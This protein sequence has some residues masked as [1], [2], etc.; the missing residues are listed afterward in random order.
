MN[1]ASISSNNLLE[2][3]MMVGEGK[4][5]EGRCGIEEDE[6]V[7][8]EEGDGEVRLKKMKVRPEVIRRRIWREKKHCNDE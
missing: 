8:G 3:E 7:S 2:V 5:V 6:E 4:L 1:V